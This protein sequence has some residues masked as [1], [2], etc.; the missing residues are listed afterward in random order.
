[1]I[2][3]ETAMTAR[4]NLHQLVDALPEDRLT[5]VLDYLAE[6]N[7]T[8][9]VSAETQAAIEEGLDDIRNGRTITLEEY[10]RTRGL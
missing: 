1:M 5:D 8:D 7:D 6:L 9:E 3:G 2:E 4:E 10:R